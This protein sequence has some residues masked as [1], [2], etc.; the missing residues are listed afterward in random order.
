MWSKPLSTQPSYRLW[1]QAARQL[2]LLRDLYSDF[3]GWIR[4]HRH[5]T[6]VLVRCGT[7]RWVFFF[8]KKRY[9]H[10][11]SLRSEKNQRTWDKLITFMKK[12]CYQL[13]PLSPVQVRGDPCTNQVQIFSKTENKSRPGKRANQ[14]S[15]RKTKKEQI[16]AEV[17]WDP[18]ARTWSRVWQKKY[19][20]INWNFSFSANGNWSYYYRVRAIQARPI[21]TLWITIRTKL[22]SSWNSYQKSSWDGRIEESSRVTNRWNFEKK[23]DRQS[24]TINELTARI[25][26]LQN[27]INCMN[28]SRVFQDVESVRSGPSHVP[29]Q[30]A[31][32]PPHRDPEGLLSRNNQP[33]DIWNSKGTSRNVFANPRASS[34]SPNPEGFT[35]WISNVTEDT[36][37]LTSTRQPV[38]FGERQ[39]P[40]TVLTPR[41]QTG[42]SAGN[43]FD[44]EEGRLSKDYGADQ[45]RLQISDLH[46]D[47]FLTQT[48]F[49]CWKIRFKTE[50]CTCSQFPTEA[51]HWIKKV[52][53]VESVDDLKSSRSIKGTHGPD[54]E[55]LDARI[56]SALNRI[57]HNTQ[58]KRKVSLEEQKAQKEDR[59][60]RGRQ[61][62]N[63][64]YEYFRVT[65]ANDS[66]ENYADLFTIVLRNDNIQEFD[67]QWEKFYCRWHKSHL[68][69]SWK[70]C[71]N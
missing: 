65:L 68:M 24:G 63:L 54:F 44:P 30:P 51:M 13:S 27:E 23:I 4:R 12:V 49:A 35:P 17:R 19:P 10:H 61:I 70:I 52:E 56:A 37:V 7:R 38:T 57:I 48:T 66:V 25:Q 60:F 34:S 62:A 42:P 47:K 5:G 64:I 39:I 45:Q 50:V 69:T 53:M 16:L 1:A 29:S 15:P 18:E 32:L 8:K 40:D 20:G 9:L 31:L 36:L 43:S 71:T 58:F 21:T 55:L 11:C 46:F 67:T 59:F 2:R 28:D 6:V 3:P 14:D 22:G 26:E 41:F 33:P